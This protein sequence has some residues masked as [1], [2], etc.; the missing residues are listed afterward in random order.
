MR[1]TDGP[2]SARS[3]CRALRN[4]R[5][6]FARAGTAPPAGR[7]E[8]NRS[9]TARGTEPQTAE[10]HRAELSH[11]KQDFLSGPR[12]PS[13]QYLLPLGRSRH[14]LAE[15]VHAGVQA[16]KTLQNRREKID[17]STGEL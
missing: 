7:P 6:A 3:P 12:G 15:T 2:R 9:D 16:Q 11:L 5:P 10:L 14:E 13:T 1:G 8:R 17:A 4:G